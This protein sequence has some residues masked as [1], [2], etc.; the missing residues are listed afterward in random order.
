MTDMLILLA[1]VTLIL[2]TWASLSGTGIPVWKS[3]ISVMISLTLTLAT[4]TRDPDWAASIRILTGIWF[5]GAPFLLRFHDVTLALWTYLG[6][7]AT[8]TA[9]AVAG[10]TARSLH[11]TP[12]TA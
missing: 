10:L 1:A 4:L 11:R 5:I 6:A 3:Y 2:A 12:I 7:G 8:V 9:L